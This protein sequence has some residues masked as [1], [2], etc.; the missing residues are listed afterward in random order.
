MVISDLATDPPGSCRR[1]VSNGRESRVLPPGGM[2]AAYSVV[3][4]EAYLPG[5]P[6]SRAVLSVVGSE[7]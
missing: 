5:T 3:L 1:G 6:G 2:E 7:P 4:A